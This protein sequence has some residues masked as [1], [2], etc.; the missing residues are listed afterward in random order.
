MPGAKCNVDTIRATL[1]VAKTPEISDAQ[2]AAVAELFPHDLFYC[3]H[4]RGE[5]LHLLRL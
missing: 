1:L 4:T 5:A 2:D 3:T